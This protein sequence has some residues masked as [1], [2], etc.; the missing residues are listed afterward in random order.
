VSE[1]SGKDTGKTTIEETG[2][3]K[4]Y[5]DRK[6]VSKFADVIHRVY[7][8][9]KSS[10]FLSRVF[11]D[12]WDSLEL[13]ERLSHIARALFPLLP[14]NYNRATRILIK[15]APNMPEFENWALT[16]YVELFG[17]E[18]FDRSIETMKQ[19]T[20]YGTAEFAIRPFMNRYTD[21]MMPILIKWAL[22]KNEHIRRLAAEGSRPRGVWV[23][24]IES[25]KK[26]PTPVLELLEIL[27]ADP[28]LYVRKAVANNLNDISR[29][30]PGKAIAVARRWRKNGNAH[31]KWIVK[32]GCRTLFKQGRS[33]VL[34]IFGFSSN[35]KVTINKVKMSSIKIKVGSEL[36]LSYE[37]ISNSRNKQ[38]L[39][40][41]YAV[42]FLRPKGNHNYKLFKLAEKEISAGEKMTISAKHKFRQLSTRKYCLGQHKFDLLVN[43]KTFRQINFELY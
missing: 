17:L 43:G 15:A 5:F 27:K 37:I 21:R 12:S 19:L 39:A 29:D 14:S 35:P 24:H 16:T 1:G 32:R 31:T 4:D 25:F 9:F 26:N 40:L 11:D 22:D 36:E 20:Q 10:K 7:P 33:E 30:N 42:H 23:A 2:L 8:E 34:S 6:T 28:S 3:W 13:K 18:H 41:G 38:K